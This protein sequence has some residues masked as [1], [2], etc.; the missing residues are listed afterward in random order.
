MTLAEYTAS[1]RGKRI[2]VVGVGISN[3]PLIRRLLADGCDVTA[4]DRNTYEKLGETADELRSL[5][6]R[7]SLGEEYLSN[8]DCDI[9]F[10]T[11]GM[12]PFTPELVR[13][14]ER[15][16]EITS[17]MEVFFRLCPAQIIAITGSDGKT[18]TTTIIAE[19][20]KAEGFVVH[21]GGNIGRPLL[22]EVDSIR[23][24]DYVVLELSS[25]QLHSMTCSP[26]VAVITN[27]SP[28]H[29][30][31]HPSLE[32]YIAAKK[33]IYRNQRPGARLVLNYDDPNSAVFAKEAG[34]EI[35][36]FS[37]KTSVKSGAFLSDGM[38][39]YSD[40]YSVEAVIPS[41]D[42]F[43]P[44]DHNI[45]NFMAAF[46]ATRGKVSPDTCREVAMSFKGVPHRLE[47]VRALDGVTYIN[48]SI[49]SSPSRTI[50]GLRSV[51]T[52]P[53]LIA[54]GYDKHIPFDELGDVISARA[55]M[56]I[57]T[58][59]TSQKIHD[60]VTASRV[61]NKDELKIITCGN[62]EEAVNTAYKAASPGDIVLLSPACAS[63]D[64]FKNFVERGDTFRKIVQ[65]LE[66]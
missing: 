62:L 58:G 13:A 20:L 33:N 60:A 56:L 30:D 17:E 51:K 7:L 3:T 4:C 43:I 31:V 9:I 49:A 29:L 57:L 10:R 35:L 12:H 21:V 32:D 66:N 15:G 50:A 39:Y 38:V 65:R 27:I 59:D 36:Y 26:D 19:L 61:Y 37:R 42:I 11:P 23:P 64:S 22:T 6:C 44:G 14:K 54:G 53:I 47:I 41:D 18:T 5:G 45:E 24:E 34:G 40:N 2:A 1:L 25:F 8:L 28:N 46:A 16:V 52:K 63:F 48:D 55:K